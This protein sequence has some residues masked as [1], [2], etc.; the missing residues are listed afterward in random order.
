MSY[1]KET[2]KENGPEE[3]RLKAEL[4]LNQG[5]N[6]AQSPDGMNV[7]NPECVWR[8]DCQQRHSGSVLLTGNLKKSGTYIS[9]KEKSRRNLSTPMW[10]MLDLED[11]TFSKVE[12]IWEKHF[13]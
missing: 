3:G 4:K 10:V 12:Y 9:Q 1:R 13:Y 5:I 11:S 6:Q 7:N 8:E 2:K